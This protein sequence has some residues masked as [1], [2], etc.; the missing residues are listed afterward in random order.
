MPTDLLI[1][2][3]WVSVWLFLRLISWI[4]DPYFR[5]I[6]HQECLKRIAQRERELRW[7]DAY[8][9]SLMKSARRPR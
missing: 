6:E 9:T 8:R 5:R 4:W 2:V 1:F 7:L 3:I